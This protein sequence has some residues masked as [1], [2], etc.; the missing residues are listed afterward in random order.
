[1]RFTKNFLSE[2][3][4]SLSLY[5]FFSKNLYNVCLQICHIPNIPNTENISN[6]SLVTNRRFVSQVQIFNLMH[7]LYRRFIIK[8]CLTKQSF[9][10]H[11]FV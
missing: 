4:L 5:R 7:T 2:I 8:K 11:F 3:I 6:T 1:M 9:V 10:K